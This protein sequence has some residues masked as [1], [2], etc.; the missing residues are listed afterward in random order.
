[1][2]RILGL[3]LTLLAAADGSLT[4]RGAAGQ[5]T[6][7]T[8]AAAAQH[9]VDLVQQGRCAEALPVLKR[10][11]P[12]VTDKQVRYRAA[13]AETRCGMGLHD[14]QTVVN[15]LLLLEREYPDDPEVLYIATHYFSEM[16]VR[17]SQELAAKAPSS[18][19]A[20][21][22][23]A[24]ALEAR[25]KNAEASAI[26]RGILEEHPQTPG[27]H[28]RLGQILLA[29]AGNTGS[30]EEA[31][32]EFQKEGEVD[33]LNAAAQFILGEL[34]RRADH[35]DE[36]IQSFRQAAKIDAGFSEAYLAL[37][38]S[39]AASGKFADA[40]PPLERY[41]KLEPADPAGHYQLAMAYSRT[42]NREGA[43][44]QIAQQAKVAANAK[45]GT[46]TV[47]GHAAPR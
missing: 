44:Q 27:I 45:P 1:M 40:V 23:E 13:M 31:R 34:A 17:A 33:P 24:E 42:G 38:M 4:A 32:A 8:S 20:H 19:Q 12:N 11:L 41:V 46:D 3:L 15:A 21:K 47:E 9:G 7:A 18:F 35:L 28:Y 16:G 36:A 14:S 5:M 26:Y 29:S 6:K 10:A 30:T 22:L 2:S 37:G 25:G 39:L 43:A